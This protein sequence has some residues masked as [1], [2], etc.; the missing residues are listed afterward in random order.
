MLSESQRINALIYCLLPGTLLPRLPSE[1]G[2]TLLTIKIEKIG[3][4]DAGQCIDPYITVSVKGNFFSCFHTFI[5]AALGEKCVRQKQYYTS[6]C[7]D[8]LVEELYLLS[9]NSNT[10]QSCQFIS[11]KIDFCFD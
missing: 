6:V 3:L 9:I 11:E 5:S 10:L 4:K 2:M 8:K 7:G 1:P